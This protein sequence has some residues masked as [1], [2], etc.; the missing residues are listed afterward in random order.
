[1][2]NPSKAKIARA[3]R[4]AKI[5]RARRKSNARRAKSRRT[6]AWQS[7]KQLRTVLRPLRRIMTTGMFGRWG[8]IRGEWGRPSRNDLIN[9]LKLHGV[10]PDTDCFG[11]VYYSKPPDEAT[12]KHVITLMEFLYS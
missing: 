3:R 1:M 11:A 12:R 8:L 10:F 7:R 2:G 4:K 5:A 6:A 9:C